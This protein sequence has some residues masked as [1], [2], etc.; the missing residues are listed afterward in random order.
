M[1]PFRKMLTINSHNKF[2]RLKTNETQK[3]SLVDQM[4]VRKPLGVPV[5]VTVDSSIEP[6][7]SRELFAELIPMEFH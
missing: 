3:V 2:N 5:M 6:H 7:Q 4:G 1:K